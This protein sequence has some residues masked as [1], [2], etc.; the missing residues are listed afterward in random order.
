MNEVK[1]HIIYFIEVNQRLQPVYGLLISTWKTCTFIHVLQSFYGRGNCAFQGS[2]EDRVKT[3]FGCNEQDL[4]SW[5]R[6]ISSTCSSLYGEVL[7]VCT[8][9]NLQSEA[10]FI[11]IAFQCIRSIWLRTTQTFQTESRVECRVIDTPGKKC[12]NL[13][14][15]SWYVKLLWRESLSGA[16]IK[17]LYLL[18]YLTL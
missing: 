6:F 3:F 15:W 4:W 5:R 10:R 11:A 13:F 18:L 7:C 1:K 12:L 9:G 8:N 17:L 14:I 2:F 16:M